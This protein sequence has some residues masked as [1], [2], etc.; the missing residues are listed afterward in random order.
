MKG[1]KKMVLSE[2]KEYI[3]LKYVGARCSNC[4]RIRVEIWS[5]GWHICEKCN[6]CIETQDYVDMMDHNMRVLANK[7]S[8]EIYGHFTHD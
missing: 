7:Y 2:T 4:G 8:E 6:W 5:N 3:P 1:R